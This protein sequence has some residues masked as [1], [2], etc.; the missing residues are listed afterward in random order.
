[1]CGI[2]TLDQNGDEPMMRDRISSEFVGS[3]RR[4]LLLTVGVAAFLSAA[5]M[6]V[7]TAVGASSG[8][9]K[10]KQP[11]AVRPRERAP[12]HSRITRAHTAKVTAPCTDSCTPANQPALDD[13]AQDANSIAGGSYFT[14]AAVDTTADT[15]TVYLHNAPQSVIDKLQAAHPGTYVIHNDAPA[16]LSSLLQLKDSINPFALRADGIDVVS[17]G[18]T[19]DGHLA[20]GVSS[21]VATARSE[22]DSK[23]PGGLIQVTRSEP[24][25]WGNLT[26]GYGVARAPSRHSKEP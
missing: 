11:T 26:G 24:A 7:Q 22:L 14:G 23:Y 12:G 15:V 10:A 8:H 2:R 1:M 21:D 20:V 3:W 5:A 16:T 25:V 19:V 6:G 9:P 18:P 17:F 13:A 4:G